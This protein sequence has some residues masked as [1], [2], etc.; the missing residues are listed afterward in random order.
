MTVQLDAGEERLAD[1]ALVRKAEDALSK[2]LDGVQ[3][4]LGAKTVAT[5]EGVYRGRGG[6]VRALGE[7]GQATAAGYQRRVDAMLTELAELLEDDPR[8]RRHR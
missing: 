8:G 2:A 3:D 5:G 4:G 6:E 1:D 7:L